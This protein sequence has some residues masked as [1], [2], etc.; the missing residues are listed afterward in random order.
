MFSSGFDDVNAQL[1][2]LAR[3]VGGVV[4]NYVAGD[5]K[6]AALFVAEGTLIDKFEKITSTKWI[7]QA[8][9]RS[10][11]DR[12]RVLKYLDNSIKQHPT[13]MISLRALSTLT[14][15]YKMLP[16]ATVAFKV[17]MQP[18]YDM[19]WIPRAFHKPGQGKDLQFLD[20]QTHFSGYSL[21]WASTFAC[22]ALFESGSFAIQPESLKSVLAMSAGDSLYIAAPLLCDPCEDTQPH[23]IRRIR[24]NVGRPGFAMLIPPQ[25]PR[26]REF[27]LSAWQL[28]N[29]ATFDG[30][31]EDSFQTTSLHLSFT[32]YVLPLDVGTHG[33]RDTEIYFLESLV[34]IHDCGKWVADLD[35]LRMRR[36]PY[37]RR[38][39]EN[40]CFLDSDCGSSNKA[41]VGHPD[42]TMVDNW[43][44]FLDRPNT[45][46][47]VRSCGN[48]IGRSPM[49]RGSS[50]YMQ[51]MHVNFDYQA[52]EIKK[53][54]Y[55]SMF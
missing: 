4:F 36:A 2:P 40:T 15:I 44:E 14:N 46:I 29:H 8:F 28:V 3:S 7:T 49:V 10:A 50:E 35:I 32:E 51:L 23:E 5:V 45:T 13:L 41:I 54:I 42:L 33:G 48:W 55:F 52:N 6:K 18:L 12:K 31:L 22:I 17:T 43:M 30:H 25:N 38:V 53:S 11:F 1:Y 47:I 24:G 39:V 19:P 34:S 16:S 37:F 26:T 9:R 21:D 27:D 20:L